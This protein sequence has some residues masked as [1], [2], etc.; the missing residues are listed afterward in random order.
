MRLQFVKGQFINPSV[1][2]NVWDVTDVTDL[3]SPI[4]TMG[5]A[6]LDYN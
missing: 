2:C 6:L 1:G 4:K 5:N 3:S